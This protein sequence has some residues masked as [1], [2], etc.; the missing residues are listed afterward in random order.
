MGVRELWWLHGRKGSDELRVDFLA[1]RAGSPP[2]KVDASEVLAGL[3]LDDV[4]EAVEEVRFSQTLADRTE[5][6]SRIVLRRQ[7]TIV[8]LREEEERYAAS[9]GGQERATT[10]P[11]L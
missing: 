4:C 11:G 1:L 6:V 7:R 2:R 8:R 10:A 3:T 9:P 5:A